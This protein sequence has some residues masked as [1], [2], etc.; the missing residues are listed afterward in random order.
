[1]LSPIHTVLLLILPI[2]LAV[3]RDDQRTIQVVSELL[4]IDSKCPATIVV[5]Q[6]DPSI[7]EEAGEE[8]E[9]LVNKFVEINQQ[10]NPVILLEISSLKNFSWNITEP[11]CQNVVIFSRQIEKVISIYRQIKGNFYVNKLVVVGQFSAEETRRLLFAIQNEKLFVLLEKIG[12]D[13]ELYSWAVNNRTSL[14]TIRSHSNVSTEMGK[15]RSVK[16]LGRHLLIATLS[17]P[18][19]VVIDVDGSIRGIEPSVMESLADHLHFT[20]DFVQASP[21]EMWG[22]I[23]GSE[24]H[25]SFTGLLG[26]LARKEVDLAVGGLYISSIRAPFISYTEVYNIGYETFL[27]PAPQPYAKWT[28]LFYS[29]TWPTWMATIASAVVVVIMLYLVANYSSQGSTSTT[30]NNVFADFQFC[31]L[32]VIG[33]LSNMQV[34]PQNITSNANR[35]FI[36]WW[37]FGALILTT[38]YRSGLISYM[39]FPFTP[40]SIDT[41]QQ[42]VDSSLKKLVFGGFLKSILLNSTKEL[43]RKIGEDLIPNY[44]LTGMFVSLGSGSSAVQSNLNNLLY[45]AATMYPTTAAGPRVHLIKENIVP[46]WVAFGLQKNSQLKPYFDKGI[47]RLIESGLIDHHTTMFA[48]KLGK[49]NPKKASNDLISFSLDSLQGAFYLLGIGVV[50][51]I[52]IFAI[53]ISL[54]SVKRLRPKKDKLFC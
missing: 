24:G 37:L 6:V 33:N 30:R 54:K 15:N 32:Y 14:T 43:E 16:L 47:Q 28:A 27:V 26:M 8:E 42:L 22:E 29:F 19:S 31:C 39:T 53:E 5:H 51:S 35:M 38:G 36:I 17:Y 21:N 45:M 40:P 46:A 20:Y 13:L 25:F 2:P 1:M 23:F 52:L 41:L 12:R 48:K 3:S 7:G 50:G 11:L 44:N 34:Q 9:G 18:P 4:M 49:W 10:S